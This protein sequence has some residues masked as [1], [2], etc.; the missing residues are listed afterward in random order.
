MKYRQ[1]NAE[2]RSALAALRSVRACAA[3]DRTACVDIDLNLVVGLV[4]AAD[5]LIPNAGYRG[6]PPCDTLGDG[7]AV[8]A[9]AKANLIIRSTKIDSPFEVTMFARAALLADNAALCAIMQDV[10]FDPEFDR[11]VIII[12]A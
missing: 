2:E 8:A 1:L 4:M 11:N 12:A 6:R 3:F 10:E 7:N 5:D 9:D